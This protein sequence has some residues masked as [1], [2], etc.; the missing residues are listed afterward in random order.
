MDLADYQ[1]GQVKPPPPP[2]FHARL[3]RSL[4]PRRFAQC[5]TGISDQVCR[6]L[7]GSAAELRLELRELERELSIRIRLQ[8]SGQ[9]VGEFVY[10]A[11][12]P[13]PIV[14]CHRLS[15]P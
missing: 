13:V 14:V 9:F 5:A 12:R 8:R 3:E 11:V 7:N 6:D 15:L 1:V 4:L 10:E 2:G